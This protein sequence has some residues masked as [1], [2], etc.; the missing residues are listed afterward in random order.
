MEGEE[1]IEWEEGENA[2]EFSVTA[3]SQ[4]AQQQN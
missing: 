4:H 3:L 2:W 1:V